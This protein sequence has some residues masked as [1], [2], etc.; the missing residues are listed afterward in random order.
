MEQVRLWPANALP[1]PLGIIQKEKEENVSVTVDVDD[2]FP[3]GKIYKYFPNQKY[4]FIKD[5]IGRE[6][7]FHLDEMEFVGSKK[8]ESLKA[9]SAVGYDLVHSGRGLHVKRIKVY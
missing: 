6:I 7:Y 5:R 3:K 8:E 2:N 9:G 1:V 4:G